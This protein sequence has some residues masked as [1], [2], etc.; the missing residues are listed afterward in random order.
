M[1][2]ISKKKNAFNRRERKGTQRFFR[3]CLCQSLRLAFDYD[4]GFKEKEC[5]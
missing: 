1:T 2:V 5:I 3:E 4:S